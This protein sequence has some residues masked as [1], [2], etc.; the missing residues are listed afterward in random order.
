M[1]GAGNPPGTHEGRSQLSNVVQKEHE[2]AT[3][4]DEPVS[5]G[6]SAETQSKEETV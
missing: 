2:L 3:L 6:H 4:A 1:E 5:E